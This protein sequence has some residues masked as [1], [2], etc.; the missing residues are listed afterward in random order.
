MIKILKIAS[1]I[2][3][4]FSIY[5]KAHYDDAYNHSESTIIQ[6]RHWMK[7]LD[8]QKNISM[9]S[10]PGTHDSASF[11]GGD[12]VQTQSMSIGEQL[13]AGVRFLDIRLRHI[14][15]VFA[16]HHGPIFQK[17]FFEDILNQAKSFLVQNPSEFILMRVQKEHTEKNNTRTFEETFLDYVN[18]YSDIVF[19]FS[20]NEYFPLV[21]EVRGKIVFLEQIP[22]SGIFP[23][24]GINYYW[25]NI[26]DDYKM[27]NN[28][29]LYEK[30]EKIKKHLEDSSSG[31]KTRTINYLSASGGSFPYFVASGHSSSGTNAPRLNTGLTTPGWKHLYPDFPRINC[32]IGM[33]SIAF[34]GTN[35]LTKNWIINNKP[36]YTGIVVA[37][38]I[39]IGL[40]NAIINSNFRTEIDNNINDSES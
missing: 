7:N 4:L 15:D 16:I 27:Y 22:T 6:N 3:L 19:I 18:K 32:F 12:I 10:I 24:F 38:F 30:W 21:S 31:N 36:K 8:D 5:A 20:E 13:N 11:Y 37:D 34:E 29:G 39:G 33:C 35:T 2:S 40:I 1:I 26:Q 9:L 28:W 17:K 23:P 14:D 25:F